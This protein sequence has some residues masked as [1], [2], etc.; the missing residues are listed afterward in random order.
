[1]QPEMA[2]RMASLHGVESSRRLTD[3]ELRQDGLPLRFAPFT[4][5]KP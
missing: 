4:A 1:V 3:D 5:A 2:R